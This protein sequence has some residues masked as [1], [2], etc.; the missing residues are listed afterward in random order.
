MYNAVGCEIS[1]A[2]IGMHAFTGCDTVSALAGH[3]KLTTLKQTKSK[4]IFQEAFTELG[5]TWEVLP[6]LHRKLQTII[7][8]MCRLFGHA[9]SLRKLPI[10][11]LEKMSG[12]ST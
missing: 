6:E 1:L 12:G 9:F 8:Q 3:G 10:S 11:D 4:K 5:Q 2:L 7:C